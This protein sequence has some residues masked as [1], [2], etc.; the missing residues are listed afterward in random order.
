MENTEI[1]RLSAGHDAKKPFTMG[2]LVEFVKY[3]DTDDCEVSLLTAC[4]ERPSIH[5]MKLRDI[6]R[7]G[8]KIVLVGE[9]DANNISE[10]PID[11]WTDAAGVKKERRE[12]HGQ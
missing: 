6:I 5:W 2:E 10:Y 11:L 3:T 7:Q 9:E 4:K 12:C 1:V 8:N